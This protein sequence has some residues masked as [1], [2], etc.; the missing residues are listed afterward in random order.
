M[1]Q[2]MGVIFELGSRLRL[3]PNGIHI[4]SVVHANSMRSEY[5]F[6]QHT[7]S[8]CMADFHVDHPPDVQ[9][10]QLPLKESLLASEVVVADG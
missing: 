1:V 8:M 9:K 2:L 5:L 7:L 10:F 6:L 3:A 4:R